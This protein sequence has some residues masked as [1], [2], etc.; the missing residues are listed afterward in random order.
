MLEISQEARDPEF[1]VAV[2]GK[3]RLLRGIMLSA[4]R[5]HPSVC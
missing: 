2:L 1:G 4:Y 5:E 3:F